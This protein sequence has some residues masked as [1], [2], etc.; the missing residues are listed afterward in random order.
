MRKTFQGVSIAFFFIGI[1]LIILYRLPPEYLPPRPTNT[2]T[3]LTHI[4][5]ATAIPTSTNTFFVART[6]IDTPCLSEKREG[7]LVATISQGKDVMIM[8]KDGPDAEWIQVRL[9]NVPDCWVE[10]KFITSNDL[11]A[12]DVVTSLPS[13]STPGVTLTPGPTESLTPTG[14]NA[15]ITNTLTRTRRPGDDSSTSLPQ[16]TNTPRSIT[17]T[18]NSVTNTSISQITK[19]PVHP[20]KTPVP[21]TKTPVPSSNTPIPPTIDSPR[22]AC[23]DGIDN[24]HDGRTDLED[25]D[26]RNRGDDSES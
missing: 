26:C 20:T 5:E 11:D 21:P 3:P 9:F 16:R 12:L 6:R 10:R 17:N 7:E 23:N 15:F 19:T 4:P 8:G 14:T 18:P 24:D 22:R 25:P 13:T 2:P 1:V